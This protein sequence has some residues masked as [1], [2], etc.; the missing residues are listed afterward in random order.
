[1]LA[2]DLAEACHRADPISRHYLHELV[3]FLT[4]YAPRPAWGSREKVAAWL[5]DPA[6]V[7]E[8]FE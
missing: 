2:N 6:P 7:V 4:C 8:V 5:A 1:V 3:L